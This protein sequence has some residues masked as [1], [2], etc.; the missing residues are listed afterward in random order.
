MQWQFLSADSTDTF[1]VIQY[2]AQKLQVPYKWKN[3]FLGSPN[4]EKGP[5]KESVLAP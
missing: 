4:K 1:P 3:T 2:S 5:F